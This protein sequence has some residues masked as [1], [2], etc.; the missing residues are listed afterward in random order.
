M[1]DVKIIGVIILEDEK[2]TD[3][4]CELNSQNVNPHY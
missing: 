2:G 3:S 1:I 4:F